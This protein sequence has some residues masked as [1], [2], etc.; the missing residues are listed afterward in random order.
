MNIPNYL[1]QNKLRILQQP[2]QAL[3][4]WSSTYNKHAADLLVQPLYQK[5]PSHVL[6]RKDVIQLF[7]EGDFALAATAAMMW[8]AISA[9]KGHFAGFLSTGRERLAEITVHLKSL[10][11]D[12]KSAEA[13]LFMQNEGKIKGVRYPYFTKLFFFI[14]A[15]S[16]K[17]IDPV[18]LIFDKWTKNAYYAL[19]TQSCSS[20][21]TKYFSG[22]KKTTSD[23]QRNGVSARSG[24][25]LVDSYISYIND[26]TVW[27][28]QLGVEPQKLEEFVFGTSRKIDQ[29]AT[30]PR[31][32]LIAIILQSYEKPPV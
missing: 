8:G 7:R 10:I 3:N 11:E 1:N 16:G 13:F 17:K 26:M 32:E 29:S 12:G 4:K 27:S 22:T 9:G 23:L 20:E 19:L 30:N 2:D 31:N 15:S 25:A 5:F 28:K 24:R 18:P 6:N 14:A 21:V